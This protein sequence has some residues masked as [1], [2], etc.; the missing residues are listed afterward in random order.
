MDIGYDHDIEVIRNMVLLVV[1]AVVLVERDRILRAPQRR[2]RRIY[3]KKRV[4]MSDWLRNR[5]E[6]GDYEHLMQELNREDDDKKS[7]K[8]Y[9]RIEPDLFEEMVQRLTPHLEKQDTRFRDSLPVGLKLAVTLRHMASGDNYASLSYSFRVSKSAISNFIPEVCRAIYDV[10]QPEYLKVPQTPE[11][12]KTVAEG[13]SQKWNYH[14]CLGALDGKH[15]GMKKPDQG[16]SVYYNYKK[17]NSIILM[18]LVDANYKFL[19]VDVGAEGSAGNAGTWD[20]CG[21]NHAIAAGEAGIP[22]ATPIPNDDKPIPYHIIG[23]DAFPMK[24]WLMKPY[25]HRTQDEKE[26]IYSYRLSRARRVVENAF[27]IMTMR[28]RIFASNM[29][30]Q[31]KNVKLITLAGCVLH[32][33]LLDRYPPQRQVL[34]HE[35]ADNNVVPG[36]WRDHVPEFANL[37]PHQVRNFTRDCKNMRNYLAQYYSSP[38]GAVP[39][40]DRMI[41]PHRYNVI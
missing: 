33:L 5:I 6:Q 17:F 10:Y 31:T 27:G 24:T 11:E 7:F 28:F 19:Y 14:N 21:M 8:N 36:S 39:W 3:R 29:L 4:W 23:D 37:P 30:Q 38:A 40:Q 15:I 32:N 1:A 41:N 35:D 12:W 2:R 25:S 18:G 34:D 13:F 22:D 16:G 20:R 9:L 26:R